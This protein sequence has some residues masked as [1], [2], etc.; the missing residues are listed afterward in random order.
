MGTLGLLIIVV[1]AVIFF[2]KTLIRLVVGLFLAAIVY[3]AIMSQV[4]QT[5]SAGVESAGSMPSQLLTMVQDK[6]KGFFGEGRKI[7]EPLI[8]AAAEGVELYQYCLADTT[9]VRGGV[10]P[11]ACQALSGSERTACFEHAAGRRPV[12]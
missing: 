5:V 11:A 8:G 6:I 4:Q 1:V 3:S 12:L 10:T 7:M 2:R 9:F